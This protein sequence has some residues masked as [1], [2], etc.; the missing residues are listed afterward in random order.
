VRKTIRDTLTE[1]LRTPDKKHGDM[2]DLIVEQLH[3]EEPLINENFAVDMVST[4]LFA[5]IYT[6][7]AII[8]ITFKSLHDNPE[9]VRALKVCCILVHTTSL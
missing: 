4:L 1:R 6:L 9:V 7:A 3:C 8:A 5:G 2:L